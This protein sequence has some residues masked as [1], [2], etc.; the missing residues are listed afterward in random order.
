MRESLEAEFLLINNA[1]INKLVTEQ[2][3]ELTNELPKKKPA[4]LDGLAGTNNMD[5]LR[6]WL[7]ILHL[8]LF[9]GL[10]L[11]H[12]VIGLLDV[13]VARVRSGLHIG[14]LTEQEI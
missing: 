6:G 1:R 14:L 2:V 13:S 11:V 7:G 8:P 10:H 4:S 9:D 5:D 12:Q 3:I